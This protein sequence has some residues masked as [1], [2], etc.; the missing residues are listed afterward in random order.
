MK[1][2]KRTYTQME[3]YTMLLDWKNQYCQKTVL[4]KIIYRFNAITIKLPVTFFTELE[5]TILSF[6]WKCKR[7]QI[8]KAILKRKMELEES[9]SLTST[10]LQSY[11]HQNSMVLA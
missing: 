4:P 6:V 7:S 9:D 11:S 1:E 3:R 10:I 2:M 5:Q 8:G